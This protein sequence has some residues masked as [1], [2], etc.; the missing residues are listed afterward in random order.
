MN[1]FH[2]CASA[3]A[4]T[5]S[6]LVMGC[7]THPAAIDYAGH[8]T[9]VVFAAHVQPQMSPDITR[10][11][12]PE[13]LVAHALALGEEDRWL[14]AGDLFSELADIRSRD[15]SWESRCYAAAALCYMHA[16]RLDACS[17]AADKTR[18]SDGWSRYG[19]P[20]E[21]RIIRELG[22]LVGRP[23]T[24]AQLDSELDEIVGNRN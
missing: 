1:K 15:G 10:T 12:S 4:A 6:L 24:G 13:E 22:G 20:Y 21:V 3:A 17:T 11:T 23:L 9:D 14:D 2:I 8:R 18:I 5:L 19:E 7:A 16:G